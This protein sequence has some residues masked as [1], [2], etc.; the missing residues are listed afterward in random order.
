MLVNTTVCGELDVP[1]LCTPNDRDA[2]D[3]PPG[4]AATP[5]PVSETDCGLA[6]PSSLTRS[7][8]VR[9]PEAVGLNVTLIVQP[10]PTASVAPHEVVK[11]KSEGLAPVMAICQM[12]I[13]LLPKLAK[14]TGWDV[15]ATPTVWLGKVRLDGDRLAAAPTP[16]R[17]INC[18][19]S[20]ASSAITIHPLRGPDAPGVKV[21]LTVQL[22]LAAR[23]LG[24]MGQ[25]LFSTV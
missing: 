3:R 15:L 12:L 1:T 23:V 20:P 6:P 2:A 17:I 22:E 7:K 19:L 8:A 16:V 4:A 10:G 18:G 21:I 11:E 14:V 24:E 13:G 25:G 5:V 9:V